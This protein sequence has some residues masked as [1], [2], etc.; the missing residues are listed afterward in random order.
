MCASCGGDDRFGDGRDELVLRDARELIEPAEVVGQGGDVALLETA[1]VR[2]GG[3]SVR[4]PAALG[5]FGGEVGPRRSKRPSR[6]MGSRKRQNATCTWKARSSEGSALTRSSRRRVSLLSVMPYTLRLRFS[7]RRPDRRTR[8]RARNPLLQFIAVRLMLLEDPE[9]R[10]LDHEGKSI[11]E[12]LPAHGRDS[13]VVQALS[14]WCSP[15]VC[16]RSARLRWSCIP[17]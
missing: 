14:I 5:H 6:A 2:V 4:R 7:S 11:G 9:D 8:R 12:R 3:R 16:F 17:T 1:D 13:G 10:H 15:S